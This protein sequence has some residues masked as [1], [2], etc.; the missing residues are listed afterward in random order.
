[1]AKDIGTLRERVSIEQQAGAA[2]GM[3]G[4]ADGWSVV[5][6]VYARVEQAGGR[7]RL[8][9]ATLQSEV[10]WK[11]TLRY[12]KDF[13]VTA[14]M[15]AVW[16]GMAMNIRTVTYDQTKRFIELVCEAGVAI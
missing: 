11:V 8:Q 14:G 2:D 15:R 1:M 9:A 12:S 13:T 7:E 6:T 3:G 16:N 5:A 10:Q 4:V